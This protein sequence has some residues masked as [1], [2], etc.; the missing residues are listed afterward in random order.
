MLRKL[1]IPTTVV[2]VSILL[3]LTTLITLAQ[4]ETTAVVTPSAPTRQPPASTKTAKPTTKSQRPVTIIL[5]SSAAADVNQTTTG[6]TK[7]TN[8]SDSK[9]D[10][11]NNNNNNNGKSNKNKVNTKR[12]LN[13]AAE[14]TTTSLLPLQPPLNVTSTTLASFILNQ[15]RQQ[16]HRKQRQQQTQQQLQ[17]QKQKQLQEKL[18]HQQK[19]QEHYHQQQLEGIAKKQQQRRQQLQQQ[20]QKKD[21]QKHVAEHQDQEQE[22]QS[23]QHEPY[24]IRQHEQDVGETQQSPEHLINVPNGNDSHEENLKKDSDIEEYSSDQVELV[25]PL[26]TST[27]AYI[28]FELDYNDPTEEKSRPK[29]SMINEVLSN[30]F[31]IGFSDIFRFSYAAEPETEPVRE[32]QQIQGEENIPVTE[33]P[34]EI[35]KSTPMPF[36]PMPTDENKS[37]EEIIEAIATPLP[38]K[39]M[40]TEKSNYGERNVGEN[41]PKA[42]E[43]AKLASNRL[44][45]RVRTTVRPK[46]N[47][48]VVEAMPIVETKESHKANTNQTQY[49]GEQNVKSKIA[50][51]GIGNEKSTV[52]KDSPERSKAESSPQNVTVLSTYTTLTRQYSKETSPGH[53]EIVVEKFMQDP[54]LSKSGEDFRDGSNSISREELLR[55]NRAAKEASVLPSLLVDPEV[56]KSQNNSQ[57]N[58]NSNS[59]IVILNNNDNDDFVEAPADDNQIAETQNFVQSVYQGPPQS[60]SYQQGPNHEVNVH[61]VHDDKIRQAQENAMQNLQLAAGLQQ[62]GPHVGQQGG[63]PIAIQNGQQQYLSYQTFV[64]QAKK[65]QNSLEEAPSRKFLK[66]FN[67][68][69]SETSNPVPVA[70]GN[71]HYEQLPENHIQT[72]PP[73]AQLQYAKVENSQPE[74]QHQQHDQQQQLFQPVQEQH[75]SPDYESGSDQEKSNLHTT[76]MDSGH[77]N[78][79]DA[80]ETV[81]SDNHDAQ[82]SATPYNLIFVTMNTVDNA[83]EES[84]SQEPVLGPYRPHKTPQDYVYEA[85]KANPQHQTAQSQSH[86]TQDHQPQESENN[87]KPSGSGGSGGGYT[88]VEVQKSIN[89]HNKL[90]TEKDGRLIEQH[91]TIYPEPQ[92]GDKLQEPATPSSETDYVSLSQNPIH[93]DEHVQAASLIQEQQVLDPSQSLVDIGPI[94]QSNLV[95]ESHIIETAAGESD[96]AIA[97]SQGPYQAQQPLILQEIIEKHIHIP[98]AVP[99]PVAVPVHVQHFIDRPFPVET[100]VEKP[101]PYP[102]EKV[103]EKV[104]EKHVPVQVQKVVEKPVEKIV[105]KYVDRPVAIPIKIPVAIQLPHPPPHPLF[106]HQHSD[107]FPPTFGGTGPHPWSAPGH[108]STL[109]R[110]PP[111]ILQAY[112][113]KMLKKLVPQMTQA[114]KSSPLASKPKTVI[115]YNPKPGS[116]KQQSQV[117]DMLFDLKPPPPPV[118]G[119]SWDVGARYQY[120]YNTLPYDLSASSSTAVG[121]QADRPERPGP[122]ERPGPKT[123]FDEFQRWRNGHSLKRSP[124]LGMTLHMEYGFKPPLV[125]S[126]EID[127]KGM[128]LKAAADLT[129]G[130]EE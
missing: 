100:I 39:P 11:S 68:S 70:R 42:K 14:E 58:Q 34:L 7:N 106:P 121:K 77:L 108:S 94:Q 89:I 115:K 85:L 38:F 17:Q 92:Y 102:V 74:P 46:G 50:N 119:P 49:R 128:P 87:P 62:I 124:E 4:T 3:V 71:F 63:R 95:Q 120:D 32:V 55:I 8:L 117:S 129:K 20:H 127:D 41:T 28:P 72:V 64:E 96:K 40:P 110:I 83:K 109:T 116:I 16:Q 13:N 84:Q 27:H 81:N 21:K 122:L 31:P 35:I 56:E 6:N 5:A 36:K 25:T 12:L 67:P 33:I 101:V 37:L 105:E 2:V 90:I 103:V 9:N 123:N 104:V 111:K 60:V 125:P 88:F 69:L 54:S 53:M 73:A 51:Q 114:Y 99:E 91:E 52:R 130:K 29:Q 48:G 1:L 22:P 97:A 75:Y 26:S 24:Q 44:P 30:L 57:Q 47:K 118:L 98:Y 59:P 113:A 45:F 82:Q 23:Q 15:Q 19:E 18:Q 86:N 61:I 10:N 79:K 65:I 43:T 93:V 78:D 126:V 80:Y 107:H 66:H 76:F 112:Y